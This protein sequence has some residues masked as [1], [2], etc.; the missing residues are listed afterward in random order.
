MPPPVA[1]S[2][3]SAGTAAAG[4][5]PAARVQRTSAHAHGGGET[6]VPS[7][8]H[9]A[10]NSSGRPLDGATRAFMEQ[11]FGHDFSNVRVHTDA[12]A[13]ESARSINALAYTSGR[14]VVFGAGQH[15]TPTSEGKRL[16]AH[17]LTH[18][19]QQSATAPG[20][21]SAGLTPVRASEQIL[22]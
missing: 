6:A 20:T 22:P 3:A 11:R 13:A 8:V 18:V 17:E 1:Q 14:D 21:G 16:L 5:A 9:E 10:L 7:I 19:I 15:A 12:R 4:T 2:E